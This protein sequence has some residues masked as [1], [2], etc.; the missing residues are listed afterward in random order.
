MQQ[1]LER[2]KN[3]NLSLNR[4]LKEEENKTVDVSNRLGLASA[5]IKSNEIDYDSLN[6]DLRQRIQRFDAI[7]REKAQSI[8]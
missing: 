1:D 6:H 5:N 2:I 7:S 4:T 8:N 3:A